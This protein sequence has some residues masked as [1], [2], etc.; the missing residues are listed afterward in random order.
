[1]EQFTDFAYVYDELNVNYD[2][3]SIIKRL[4]QLLG[5]CREV[6]DLC[7]GTGDVAIALARSGYKVTG[8]DISEDMLN[9]ATGKAMQSA[10]RVQFVCMDARELKLMKKAD[11]VYSV[12]DGMNYML[13]DAS[14]KRAFT[15]VYDSLNDNGLFVFDMSTEHKFECMLDDKT[16]IFD[17]D[18]IFVSWQNE[19]DHESRMCTMYLTGFQKNDDDTYSRFDEE[20]KQRA[21]TKDEIEQMLDKCGFAVEDVYAGYEDRKL[22]ENDERAL[23]VARKRG[24]RV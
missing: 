22:T 18:D 21:Y 4:K 8:I 10:A 14:L 7:C 12:T 24:K 9:V 3:E 17:F 15:S 20:H 19:Y 1:M 5:G 13:D 23:Y 2:K 16:Y 11:A 6:A